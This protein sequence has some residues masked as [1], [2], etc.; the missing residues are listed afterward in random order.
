MSMSSFPN[1][2]VPCVRGPTYC[3]GIHGMLRRPASPSLADVP[4]LSSADDPLDGCH[5]IDGVTAQSRIVAVAVR[6]PGRAAEHQNV[7]RDPRKATTSAGYV[8]PLAPV[9]LAGLS[10]TRSV[11]KPAPS[12]GRAGAS[13][14]SAASLRTLDR[15]ELVVVGRTDVLDDDAATERVVQA[16]HVGVVVELAGAAVDGLEG[17]DAIVPADAAEVGVV[18]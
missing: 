3:D 14:P 11:M 17:A 18:R 7:C 2:I 9:D 6:H 1:L 8:G 15:G 10:R 4:L 13:P 5:R 16:T 12:P